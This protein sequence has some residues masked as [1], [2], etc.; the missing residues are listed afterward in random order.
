MVTGGAATVLETF[1]AA[2]LVVVEVFVDVVGTAEV[3]V[4]LVEE[5]GSLVDVVVTGAVEV[6]VTGAVVVVVTAAV[7]VDSLVD[8]VV[9]AAV[10]VDSLVVVTTTVVGN[11]V[12]VAATVVRGTVATA[13]AVWGSLRRRRC[14]FAVRGRR[15]LGAIGTAPPGGPFGPTDVTGSTG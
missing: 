12:V 5:V 8:V 14:S 7:V 4:G 15:K 1:A 6:V 3:V 2:G 9:T 13:T 10:V 11:L